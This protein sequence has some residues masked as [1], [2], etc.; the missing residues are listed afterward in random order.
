MPSSSLAGGLSLRTS[1]TVKRR[2]FPGSRAV[3][4][5][6]TTVLLSLSF[7]TTELP[8]CQSDSIRKGAPPL[9]SGAHSAVYLETVR[10]SQ[11]FETGELISMDFSTKSL[12]ML[13]ALV[14]TISRFCCYVLTKCTE[15]IC[16]G[17][18]DDSL[19]SL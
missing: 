8:G 3:T 12:D 6:S 15:S 2:S 9:K 5:P 1:N 10:T 18:F 17:P 7:H 4:F 16:S 14:K 13:P 19:Y 11:T